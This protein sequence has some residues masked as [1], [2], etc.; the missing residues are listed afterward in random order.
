M[1]PSSVSP[2]R[3]MPAQQ[4]YRARHTASHHCRQTSMQWRR[5]TPS[6]E[7]AVCSSLLCL[8][9]PHPHTELLEKQVSFQYCSVNSTDAG[10]IGSKCLESLQVSGYTIFSNCMHTPTPLTCYWEGFWQV[11]VPFWTGNLQL[12]A[13]VGGALFPPKLLRRLPDNFAF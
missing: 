7:V 12:K 13:F 8:P 6:S 4:C 1:E 9:H 3:W 5:I 10:P 11:S 2:V